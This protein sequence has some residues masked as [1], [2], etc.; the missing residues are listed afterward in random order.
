MPA[1]APPTARPVRF[2]VTLRKRTGQVLYYLAVI[3]VVVIIF[4]PVYWMVVSTLQP[5][6][7]STYYP[8]PLF[9]K[10]A[11]LD[12]FREV[13]DKYGVGRW[14]LHSTILAFF[15]T[16]IVLLLSI[17]GAFTLSSLRWRGRTVFAIFLLMTQML[18]EALIVVPI[19]KIFTNFPIIGVDLRNRLFGLSMLDAAFI[20]PIGIW[21]LK[22]LYDT[23][24]REVQEAARVDGASQMR[25]LFQIVMPLTLP[26]LAAVGVI[27][28]F[29]AWNEYLF[30]QL[31][32]SDNDLYPASVGLGFMKTMLDTPI[33]L[34]LAAGLIFAIPPVF[35]YIAMQR[36]I[37]AGITAGAVKG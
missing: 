8:P 4:F 16:V 24:P 12:V 2:Q 35:F 10:G 30:A 28:F 33:E 37:V 3:L 1:A 17:F 7:Y 34:Q 22:N 20:L 25:V 36:Y 29:Y 31:M 14:I 32:I 23:I 15:S 21:V 9:P 5:T 26:G 6:K 13:F 19:F 11:N 27:A 18:P